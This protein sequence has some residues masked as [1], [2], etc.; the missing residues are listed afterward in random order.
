MADTGARRI[1]AALLA[2][3]TLGACAPPPRDQVDQDRLNADID[4]SIGGLGTCIIL[5]DTQSGRK[6]YQYGKY[7]ICSGRLPPCQTFLPVAA[8][9]GLDAGVITPGT[10]LRWDGTP[11]P[12]KLWQV[13]S[14]L[15][16]AYRSSNGWWFGRLSGAIGRDRYARALQSLDYGDKT[17]TGP[18]A[19]FWQGPAQGGGLGV[20]PAGQ[21]DF[22]RR[23]WAGRLPVKPASLQAVQPLM[24]DER[25][26]EAQI[27]AVAGSCADQAD[28]GRGVGWWTGRLKSAGRDLVFAAA[29]EAAEPPPGSEVAVNLKA[30]FADV[31]LWPAN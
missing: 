23:F 2:G 10:V 1:L 25:R 4:R 27:S 22:M 19:S 29:V 28:R 12:T 26:G 14:N 30:I 15:A 20:S 11:L 9:I 16:Q 24:A 5:L 6:I 31:G 13:D 7:D 3:L 21:A 8:L 17:P 18:I